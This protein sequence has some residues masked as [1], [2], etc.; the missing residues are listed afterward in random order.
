ML[1]LKSIHLPSLFT[2]LNLCFYR[3]QNNMPRFAHN[4]LRNPQN[5]QSGKVICF[6]AAPFLSVFARDEI[7]TVSFRHFCD[8]QDCLLIIISV[9]G[10]VL[11]EQD[12]KKTLGFTCRSYA[13]VESQYWTAGHCG[14]EGRGRMCENKGVC[15]IVWCCLSSAC[16]YLA[17]HQGMTQQRG[18]H[19]TDQTKEVMWAWVRVGKSERNNQLFVSEGWNFMPRCSEEKSTTLVLTYITVYVEKGTYSHSAPTSHPVADVFTCMSGG[20]V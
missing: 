3:S 4:L 10:P 20:A 1:V 6:P 15:M 18:R 5:E 17:D 13:N 7:Y 19:F 2:S 9:Q 14:W 11:Q 16:W 8:K 12:L